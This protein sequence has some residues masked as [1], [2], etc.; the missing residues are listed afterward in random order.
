MGEE[1]ED[2]RGGRGWERKT[3]GSSSHRWVYAGST[4]LAGTGTPPQRSSGVDHGLPPPSLAFTT[5]TV[6]L[7]RKHALTAHIE[8]FLHGI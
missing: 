7:L 1:D 3:T 4:W 2:G 8:Q 5:N 6:G